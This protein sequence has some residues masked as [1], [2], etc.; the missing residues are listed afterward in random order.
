MK[1]DQNQNQGKSQDKSQTHQQSQQRSSKD[2][3]GSG[4]NRQCGTS[5]ACSSGQQNR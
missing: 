4:Q 1:Q 3:A 2:Q 5:G